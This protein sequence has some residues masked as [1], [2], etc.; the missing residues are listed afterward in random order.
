MA[1]AA[2]GPKVEEFK[3]LTTHLLQDPHLE[4]AFDL[5]RQ[6][7]R[8]L[9]AGSDDLLQK[10]Q[11]L[12]RATH[13]QDLRPDVPFWIRCDSEW[14]RGHGYRDRVRGHNQ[15]WFDDA[16]HAIHQSAVRA[17]VER[18]WNQTLDRLAAILQV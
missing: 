8:I 7:V 18:E 2:V 12:G 3:A 6:A 17:L 9:E 14:G 16:S 1:A 5:V 11:L 4:E 10:S 15:A 13:T